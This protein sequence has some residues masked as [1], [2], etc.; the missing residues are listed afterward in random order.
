MRWLYTSSDV[1]AR[2]DNIGVFRRLFDLWNYPGSWQL[3]LRAQRV[4]DQAAQHGGPQVLSALLEVEYFRSAAREVDEVRRP[5][6]TLMATA[7]DGRRD[8]VALLTK[9]GAPLEYKRMLGGTALTLAVQNG[10]EGVVL[11]LL[12]AGADVDNINDQDAVTM[13]Q[14]GYPNNTPL[15][16]AVYD[17]NEGMV[18]ILLA[19]GAGFGK[20][21][22]DTMPV[23]IAALRGSCGPPKTLLEAEADANVMNSKGQSA[24]HL[25]CLH[26]HEGAVE[27]LVRHNASVTSRCDEG[28]TTC[29][30][31]A[32]EALRRREARIDLKVRLF[33]PR[34]CFSGT[35]GVMETAAA[36]RIHG[37]L[38]AASAWGRHDWLVMMRARLP[39][40]VRLPDESVLE[41]P[42]P[43][44]QDSPGNAGGTKEL[45]DD[46]VW[47]AVEG[48]TLVA[49]A[50][51]TATPGEA[52][53]LETHVIPPSKAL[54]SAGDRDDGEDGHGGDWESVVEWLLQ[55][56]DERDIFREILGFL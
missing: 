12:A 44:E 28:L 26:S 48:L 21:R 30:V 39:A 3:G 54:V 9:A 41:Q 29:D 1:A 38:Q 4:L 22:T 46:V 6:S 55:C 18:D 34:R 52:D 32:M 10:H 45:E 19:A 5:L 56:P 14:I 17:D 51:S 13:C 24:L 49:D 31:V 53:D 43:A 35:L 25:A 50:P 42:S 8:C 37:M 36:D 15:S 40:A 47:K 23:T 7:M 33:L 20:N 2:A 11:E 16:I 27:L